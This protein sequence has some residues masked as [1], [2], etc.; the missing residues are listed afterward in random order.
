MSYQTHCYINCLGPS[1]TDQQKK[2][3]VF[4]FIDKCINQATYTEEWQFIEKQKT[5]EP[6][7]NYCF[8]SYS[9]S[10]GALPAISVFGFT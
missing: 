7:K 1:W 4:F 2:L 9:L 6:H 10:I 5:A 3:E 8:L